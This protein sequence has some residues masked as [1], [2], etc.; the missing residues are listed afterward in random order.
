M[1]ETRRLDILAAIGGV[2]ALALVIAVFGI[3]LQETRLVPPD[4]MKCWNAM[5]RSIRRPDVREDL[6][7]LKPPNGSLD[8]DMEQLRRAARKYPSSPRITFHLGVLATDPLASE[9]LRHLSRLDPGNALPFYLLASEASSS[10]DWDSALKL[11]AKANSLEGLDLY[12]FPLEFAKRD[13]V[14]E[15]GL[16]MASSG[17]NMAVYSDLRDLA[18]NAARH[19]TNLH[20]GGKGSDAMALLAGVR[21]MGWALARRHDAKAMDALVGCS[22]LRICNKAGTRIAAD[23]H[24]DSELARIRAESEELTCIRAGVRMFTIEI[25]ER[26]TNR[27]IKFLFLS[28]PVFLLLISFSL[29]MLSSLVWLTMDIFRSRRLPASDFHREA[30]ARVYSTG[31]LLKLYGLLFLSACLPTLV[32]LGVDAELK[33]ISYLAIGFAMSPTLV[34]ILL[35]GRTSRLYKDTYRELAEQAGVEVHPKW[36]RV[37]IQEW[38]EFLRRAAG[39]EGGSV[40][41]LAI[42]A[43]LLSIGLKAHFNAYPWQLTKAM[44]GMPQAEM[45]YVKDLVDGKV[46]VPQKYIDE[47]KREEMKRTGGVK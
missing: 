27:T 4:E 17:A 24:N 29:C 25:T 45:K 2:L 23:M 44:G 16:E 7:A 47:V 31:R 37:P 6:Q 9:E 20:T 22:I 21:Q 15:M 41:T 13:G 33:P 5:L 36:K 30:A 38:R 19:A 1:K 18:K 12:D 46:K 32:L 34:F 11:L 26:M 3:Y 28:V 42:W 35:V 10:G 43:L 40:I 14:L 8:V 39:L